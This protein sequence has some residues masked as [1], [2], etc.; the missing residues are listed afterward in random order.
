MKFVHHHLS[1][2]EE[3]LHNTLKYLKPDG[4]LVVIAEDINQIIPVDKKVTDPCT[5]NPEETRDAIEKAGYLFEKRG[6]IKFKKGVNYVLIFKASEL[7]A[8]KHS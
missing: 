2:P 7:H 5:S 1:Q 6:N 8:M 3:F 4:R